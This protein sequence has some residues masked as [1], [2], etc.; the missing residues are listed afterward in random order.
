M[1]D[2]LLVAVGAFGQTLLLQSVVGAAFA[3][4]GGGVSTFGIRHF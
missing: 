2:L 4:A 1:R 3:R